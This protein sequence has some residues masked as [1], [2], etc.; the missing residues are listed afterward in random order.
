MAEGIRRRDLFKVIAAGGTTAALAACADKPEKLIPY[1][2]PPENI[3]FVPG[4][5]LEY[6][7]TC[8]ECPGHCGMVVK[9][10]EARAIKAEGNPDHPISQGALCIRGQASLQ[11]HYNPM[12][13]KTSMQR[14]GDTWKEVPWA[15]AEA[16]LANAIKAVGDKRQIVYLTGNAAGTRGP[17]LDK[18][19]AALG[20]SPKLVLDPLGHHNIKAANQ[21]TFR[22]AEIPQYRI[23]QATLLVNFGSEFLETWMNPVENNR[24]YTAMHAY[25]DATKRKGRFVHV[26]PHVALTGANAD[27]WVKVAPGSEPVVVLALARE[28][29]ARTHG[30]AVGADKDRLTSYLDAYTIDRAASESGA[31]ADALRSLAEDFSKADPGLALAGGNLVATTEGTQFQVAVNLLNYVAGNVGRTVLFGASR[32]IDLSSSYGEV[33]AA[34]KRMLAGE[35]KLLIVDGVNPLY[36]MPPTSQIAGALDK[37][38]LIVSLSS[39]WDETTHKAHLV[40]PGATFLE[41]WGDAFPQKGVYSLVQPVM[42]TF[43]PDVKA[44][45]DTLL[46]VSAKLGDTTFK[47]TPTYR[48]YL[49]AAWQQVQKEVG[50]SGD[51]EEFWRASLQKG[52]VFRTVSFSSSA[53][54]NPDVLNAK[55]AAVKIAGDGLVLLPTVSLRHRD[56]RGASNPWLQEICDPVSQVVWGSWAD[57]NPVTA[58]KMGIAHGDMIRIKSPQGEAELPAFLHYGVHEDA[59][60]VPLG[61]GH[62]ASGRN[63]DGY[64]VN[65]M[66]LL[67]S[68][69]DR[70]SGQ[71]AF[72]TTRVQVERTGQPGY[73]VQLDYS[74]RQLG[75]GIIQ[76]QTLDDARA[77][78][79]TEEEDPEEMKHGHP[80]FDFYPLREEQT[81]GWNATYHWGMVI[82]SDRCTGC[83]ACVAAC[84]AENN[85]A[86][87]GKTRVGLGREMPWLTI[88][89]FIEGEGDSYKTLMQPMLC[90][91]CGN[92]GC[93]P[94]C[95]VYATYHNSEGLNVQVYNRCVGTRYCSNNC[96]YKV[97]RFNWFNYEWEAPLNLQL[98]PDVTVRSK[99]VMEK[100]SFCVQR[101]TRARQAAN[102]EGRDVRDGEVTPA[103]VQTCPTKAL[104]FGNLTDPASVVSKRA[105]RARNQRDQRVRQYE[106]FPS[107]KQH[108][109]I[110]YLRKVTFEPINQEA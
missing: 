100:C 72:L 91:Q 74:P 68:A 67:A 48:D 90:Q 87:V 36:H 46:S 19:L 9:T 94:V 75:R 22:R 18:W 81:P 24:L 40:L 86:V 17:F 42:A 61:E 16:A 80:Y 54:L 1:L 66:G 110:T 37:V 83:S 79:N 25:D 63:A 76:T 41:R 98:N 44:A 20:A 64:G 38:P 104:T 103:C 32:Q 56:G 51:F 14:T 4:M 109:S 10:R 52:G 101:I 39:A 88:Q 99:G 23:D 65:V 84:Y 49:R 96:P 62:T 70:Q 59:I 95:P 77:G 43:Y 73:L 92:A 69:M 21:L 108:P 15:D 12:R 55:P 2:L 45:E 3:E 26:G 106:V 47:A 6:A 11:T 89:R 5:P 34:V 33:Q 57:L 28:V 31:P 8:M 93:E 30:K 78:K 60:A 107:L 97:R 35:V 71:F 29:L 82:D 27:H 102:A 58:K 7:T 13:L 50:A 85:L 53:R 105:L